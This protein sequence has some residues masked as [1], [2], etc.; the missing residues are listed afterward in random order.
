MPSD[1]CVSSKQ[2]ARAA[3]VLFIHRDVTYINCGNKIKALKALSLFEKVKIKSL[4]FMAM[5]SFL[6]FTSTLSSKLLMEAEFKVT[7]KKVKVFPS[8]SMVSEAIQLY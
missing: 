2:S 3:T 8:K 1:L 5:A 4:Q 6:Y 7:I